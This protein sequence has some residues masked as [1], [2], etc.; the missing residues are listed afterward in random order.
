[1]RAKAAGYAKCLTCLRAKK[2]SAAAPSAAR[3]MIREKA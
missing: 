1:M 3:R 2:D